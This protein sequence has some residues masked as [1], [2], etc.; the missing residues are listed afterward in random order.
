MTADCWRPSCTQPTLQIRAAML[1][2]IRKFFDQRGYL[3]V[4]TPCL[5]REIVIDSWLDPIEVALGK[6]RW[7]LQTSPEAFM[8]RLLAAGSGS[9]YQIC[10]VF[11]GGESGERH[12][13]EFTMVEWYGVGT[14]W[15]QQM[16][17][18][19]SLVRTSMHAAAPWSESTSAIEWATDPF[20]RTTYAEAFSRIFG[21]DIYSADCST[22]LQIASK[23]NIPLPDSIVV[24]GHSSAHQSPS[25]RDDILNAMLAFAVEPTLGKTPAGDLAPEFLCDYPPTQAA[26]AVTSETEPIVAR[27]FELYINALELCNGYQELTDCQELQRREN[28]Q[29][30]V[31]TSANQSPLPGAPRLLSAM[32]H[33]LPECSGVALGFDRL[34][35]VALGTNQI[36]DVMP[37]PVAGA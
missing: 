18:T 7:Y 8:K 26:L 20:R 28:R 12:N 31:R 21:I 24:A 27:R 13:P 29:N 1:K 14:T 34:M 23:S 30:A 3:E 4:E 6:E 11:R 19:E 17:L 16:K 10:R 2:A 32:L 15:Q 35:M 9:I 37:F 36:A 5:S 22:L 25:L 33:G